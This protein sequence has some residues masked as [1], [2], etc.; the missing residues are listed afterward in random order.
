MK[1]KLNT[2]YVKI[3]LT[4][5]IGMLCLAVVLSALNI[6]ASKQVYVQNFEASQEK[7]FQQIDTSIYNFFKDVAEINRKLNGSTAVK[8]YLTKDKWDSVIEERGTL[9]NL[10]ETLDSLPVD[11]FS[12]TELILIGINGCMI[13]TSSSLFVEESKNILNTDVVK[14]AIENPKKLFCEYLEKGFTDVTKNYGVIVMTKAIQDQS[15][16]DVVGVSVLTVKEIDFCQIYE[17]FT[18]DTSDIV[19]FNENG[20]VIS[21]NRKN[22]IRYQSEAD[23]IRNIM[24]SMIEENVHKKQV[25]KYS[26]G[27]LYMMQRLQSSNYTMMGIINPSDAFMDAYNYQYIIGVSVLVTAIVSIIIFGLIREQTAPLSKLVRQMEHVR[28]GEFDHFAK[29]RGTEDVKEVALAYNTMLVEIDKYI[30]Q[31]INVEKE[32]REAEL[33]ALQ[34]QINPHYIYNTLASVKWLIWQG[35]KEKS[36]KVIDA[37]ITLLRNTISNKQ[38]MIPLKQEIENLQHYVYINQ[39]R[40]GNNISVEYY[41]L[42]QFEDFM[43]PKLILQPF[44]ENAFFHAFPD[45]QKGMITVFVKKNDKNMIIEIMD[46]GVGIENDRLS[47][48]KQKHVP[49]KENFTGIGVNNVDNRI[50]LIYG[51]EYG[52]DIKSTQGKGTTITV[53]FPL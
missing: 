2:L 16:G 9:L 42:P 49:K 26:Y 13:N 41:M 29:V 3:V 28:N 45:G 19:I 31:L 37:F 38:E 22:L 44:V 5:S 25:S 17:H 18:G 15:N 47:D 51:S 20:Q 14:C 50:K 35:E 46:D 1:R 23:E 21:S 27:E 40:Y 39:V 53:R 12:Q 11:N 10:Q 6:S 48:I 24:A 7:I 43:V 8:D 34:M 4:V 33:H 32:K 30:T 52:V 36:I